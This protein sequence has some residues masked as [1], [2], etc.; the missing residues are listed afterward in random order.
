MDGRAELKFELERGGSNLTGNRDSGSCIDW[1]YPSKSVLCFSLLCIP[2]A[3]S[4]HHHY[5]ITMSLLRTR[6]PA[7]TRSL[8][9]AVAHPAPTVTPRAKSRASGVEGQVRSN[10]L[11]GEVQQVWDTPLMELVFRAAGVHRQWHDP[12][13]IQLCTLM[14][15]KSESSRGV[16]R[17]A[18]RGA[19]RRRRDQRRVK[20]EQQ[21]PQPRM[22]RAKR[23]SQRRR[24]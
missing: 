23:E 5:H 3:I 4:V 6:V 8:A 1:G 12:E 11:R 24:Q 19:K 7:T 22:L 9:T 18:S 13:R 15:I 2:P 14:N 20:R 10:W 16:S 17:G 21:G